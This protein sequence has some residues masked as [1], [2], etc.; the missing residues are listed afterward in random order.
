[1][2]TAGVAA[3]VD[4]CQPVGEKKRKEVI[5]ASANDGES[6]PP[7]KRVY[8]RYECSAEGCTTHAKKGGVCIAHGA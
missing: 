6:G 1:M 7:K 2:P 3:A 8:K 5:S 4:I